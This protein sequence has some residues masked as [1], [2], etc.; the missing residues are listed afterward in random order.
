MLALKLLENFA[1]FASRDIKKI[2]RE[3]YENK[4]PNASTLR[5]PDVAAGEWAHY[6]VKPEYTDSIVHLEGMIKPD[7]YIS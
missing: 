5:A 3:K 4:N 1:F 7:L 2:R 6:S